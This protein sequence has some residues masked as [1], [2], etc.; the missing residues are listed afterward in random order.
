MSGVLKRRLLTKS[1]LKRNCH[2]NEL[3]KKELPSQRMDNLNHK[4]ENTK[5]C[6]SLKVCNAL[7]VEPK[8]TDM[9]K[10]SEEIF[11]KSDLKK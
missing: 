7:I 11:L 3:T 1:S 8:H 2:L 5:Q 10:K 9:V 6:A 4:Q